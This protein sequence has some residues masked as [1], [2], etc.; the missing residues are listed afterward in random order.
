MSKHMKV[1]V[2]VTAGLLSLMTMTVGMPLLAM[3]GFIG[4]GDPLG[5]LGGLRTDG[6]PPAAAVAYQRA[7]D[8]ARVFAPPCEIPAWI[9]A[10]VG[11]IE[12]GHGTSG[13]ATIDPYGN[14]KPPIIG[15]PLPNLGG[16]TDEGAWDGSTTVDRAVGPMQFIPATW[17]SYGLDGN[18]DGVIDPHNIYDA[19]MTA[20][21]YLCASGGPMA[22][23]ADWRRGLLAYNRSEEYVSAVLDAAYRY[24]QDPEQQTSY[25]A[26]APV[27]LVNVPGIGLTNT[28]WAVQVQAMLASAAADGVLL[29]GSSYR[30]SA[31]QIALRQVNCGTS[32]YAIYEMPA[33]QCSPPTARP[34]TSN[35]ERGLAVD[36]DNCSSPSSACY[37][38]LAANASRF[39]IYPLSSENWH[40][41]VDGR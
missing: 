9:L 4:S 39:G 25:L 20:A 15:P 27:N 38:W 30:D 14:V 26:G 28:S 1:G 10:G 21:A 12:S 34:G 5:G 3:A 19:A 18:D 7:A 13:G 32:Y 40:W 6:I 23:E 11:E 16:D 29:T 41:S 2:G 31:E 36:F 24:R 33:S 35:H 37:R 8:A 17:R 22:T